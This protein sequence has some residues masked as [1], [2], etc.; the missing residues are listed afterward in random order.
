MLVTLGYDIDRP[1]R[2]L[3]KKK[4]NWIL[5]TDEQLVVPVYIGFDADEVNHALKRKIEPS[6]LGNFSS[7]K[8]YVLTTFATTKRSSIKKRITK[9]SVG[10][11]CSLC[12]GKRLRRE[13]L[14]VPFAGFDIAEISRISMSQLAALLHPRA[15][16]TAAEITQMSVAHPEKALVAHSIAED[17]VARIPVMLDLE[18]GYLTLERSTPSLSP[19]ELQRL[20]LATQIRSNLFGVVYVL[21]E[22][23]AGLHPADTEALLLALDRLKA[24]GNSL[25]VVEHEIDIIRHADWIVDI[26]PAAGAQGGHIVY[27]GEPAGLA[28][29]K[30]FQTAKYLFQNAS[31]STR[32][33]RN[34]VSWLK[35]SKI[36]R[37][38][39]RGLDIAF[40]LGIFTTVTEVSGSGKSSLVSQVLVE[41]V[42]RE[43]GHY[44]T[45]PTDVEKL[46]MQL[47][48]LVDSGNTVIVVEHDMRVVAESD[49]VIDIGPGAGEDG[50]CI[51]ASGTPT[52]VFTVKVSRTARYLAR[53][54]EEH[55]PNF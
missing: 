2:E 13:S 4:R 35:L 55:Q 53:F 24:S 28:K 41:L 36:T 9:Y 43:L 17:L 46:I 15:E 31:L 54:L 37:N 27:N 51:V 12:Q 47:N 32:L 16:G 10:A 5:F 39:L 34:A 18:L 23:S 1:W 33:P 19:G 30:D 29:I 25:F 44:R 14:S 48:A 50:G 40:P 49:W 3:P 45:P 8:R 6:Y 7:A 38:N 11:E 52:K 20:R 21:D 26:G 22:P 42:A